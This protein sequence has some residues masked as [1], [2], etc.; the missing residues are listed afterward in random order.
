MIHIRHYEIF[1]NSI[2]GLE[3]CWSLFSTLGRVLHLCMTLGNTILCLQLASHLTPHSLICY[4]ICSTESDSYSW[5]QSQ[6]VL[7]KASI[8]RIFQVHKHIFKKIW[9]RPARVSVWIFTSFVLELISYYLLYIYLLWNVMCQSRSTNS[10]LQTRYKF[11]FRSA[12]RGTSEV[13]GGEESIKGYEQEAHVTSLQSW[14]H[15]VSSSLWTELNISKSPSLTFGNLLMIPRWSALEFLMSDCWCWWLVWLIS[16][17]YKQRLDFI[18]REQQ[19][20]SPRE[21]WVVMNCSEWEVWRSPAGSC[22]SP[23]SSWCR[24]TWSSP[25]RGGRWGPS[26]RATRSTG[27]SSTASWCRQTSGPGQAAM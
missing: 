13:R 17:K 11:H 9:A 24:A 21:S 18:L 8:L 6:A 25:G 23:P 26:L 7:H 12:L 2:F 22:S 27:D 19:T 4:S 16:L 5:S 3:K 10:T 20:D 1:L 15:S 14:Y